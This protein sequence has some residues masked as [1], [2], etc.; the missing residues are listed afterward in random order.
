M[1]DAVLVIQKK[2]TAPREIVWK[3][4]TNAEHIAAWYGPEGFTTEIHSMDVR[5]GGSYYLTMT[6]PDGTKHPLRGTFLTLDAP[7][8]IVMT[9]QWENDEPKGMGAETRVTVELKEHGVE[10]EMTLTHEL[11]NEESKKM[12]DMGWNSSFQKLSRQLS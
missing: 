1:N 10:T 4:W 2:F 5:V 9:W 7:K 11:P 6:A 12:H 8:K 3:A